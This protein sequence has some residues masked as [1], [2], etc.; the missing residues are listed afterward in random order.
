MYNMFDRTIDSEKQHLNLSEEAW[1][2]IDDDIRNFYT[3][4]DKANFS[5][6]MNTVFEGFYE[7]ADATFS[8]RCEEYRAELEDILSGVPDAAEVTELLA[9]DKLKKL[10]TA[11][12]SYS[13]GEGRKFRLNADSQAIL[14]DHPDSEHYDSRGD[15]IKAVFEQYITLPGYKREQI[16]FKRKLD[17]IEAAAATGKQ[18]RITLLPLNYSASDA[19]VLKYAVKPYAVRHDK[20]NTF[21]YLIGLSRYLDE[22]NAPVTKEKISCFRLSRISDVKPFGSAFISKEKRGEIEQE[23]KQKGVQYLSGELSEIMV[24]FTQKGLDDFNRQ[25]YMR[26]QHYEKRGRLKY[27]F[28]CT[29]FQAA[30]YFS[31]LGGEAVIVS[32]E[33]LKEEL[34][35]KFKAAYEAYARQ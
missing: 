17:A 5:G 32:P 8:S 22:H 4:D 6:F 19:H 33:H 20:T 27:V 15:Y 16:F 7:Q 14:A 25:S 24:E 31:K 28:Y 3:Y 26:P 11:A 12:L 34:R 30:S 13:K 2:V 1:L 10:K 21:N 18:I 9:Q 29:E 23:I 35:E